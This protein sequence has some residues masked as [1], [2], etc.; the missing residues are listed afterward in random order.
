MSTSQQ[1]QVSADCPQCGGGIDFEDEATVIRC[2]Y[3]GS[4]LLLGSRQGVIRYMADP[5]VREQD[6]KRLLMRIIYKQVR[7]SVTRVLEQR[8]LY[9]P[10]WY[11]RGNV[12]R[13][14]IARSTLS[15][16][17]TSR[18]VDSRPYEKKLLTRWLDF[19]FPAFGQPDMGLYSLGVRASVVRLRYFNPSPEEAAEL[20]K[21]DVP[22]KQAL[23]RAL[24]SM[25]AGLTT[26][27]GFK[28]QLDRVELIGERSSLIYFPIW[29]VSCA[30]PRGKATLIIDGLAGDVLKSWWDGTEAIP[31]SSDAGLDKA[32]GL[33]QVQ[34]LP[35]RCPECGWDLP[36]H[37]YNTVHVCGNCRRAW[38]EARGTLTEVAKAVVDPSGSSL[39]T[40]MFLPFW[41]FRGAVVQGDQR[42]ENMAQL[43]RLAPQPRVV[44]WKA[45]ERKP[46]RFFIPAFKT[47]SLS[48]ITHMAHMLLLKPPSRRF[49]PR[50][51][52]EDE[53]LMG[54]YLPEAE[55]REM[56]RIVVFSLIPPGNQQ[57]YRV[58]GRGKLELSEPR[59]EWFPFAESQHNYTEAL[60]GF[61]LTRNA[62]EV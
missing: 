57:A 27:E 28:T 41:T 16:S 53:K 26:P 50:H 4:A 2:S 18:D 9:A 55:A 10:F 31:V 23:L 39:E 6:L 8:L 40:G 22:I 7:R 60:T 45:E 37:P 38:T 54:V 58:L 5:G 49:I 62:V 34:F 3:C 25:R 11:I 43:L 21:V 46:I 14:I 33:G 48:Q 24:H 20:I 15:C 19:S 29:V 30:Y 12:F 59:L 61:A 17:V 51:R 44:D 13:W 36:F 1:F 52:L 42:V 56:A 35:F 32:A 47:R